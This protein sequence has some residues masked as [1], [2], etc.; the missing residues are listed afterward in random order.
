MYRVTNETRGTVLARES[1]LADSFMRRGLGLMGKKSLPEG[2]GLVIRPCNGVVSFF[3]RFPIDVVFV[4]ANGAVLHLVPNLTPWKTSKVV[5]GS[6]LVI[7]LPAG[8]IGD[9]G[10]QVGDS[11]S[12]ERS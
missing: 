12:I 3:M 1:A 4:D 8:T 2:G 7:E 9:T 5:R 6:K 10:T 11:I